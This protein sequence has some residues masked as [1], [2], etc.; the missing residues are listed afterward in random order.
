MVYILNIQGE[1]LMPCK[2]AKARRLL[3]DGKAKVVKREPF[4]LQLLFKCEN[5][6]QDVTLGV[7]AGSTFI[8]WLLQLKH[9]NYIPQK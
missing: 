4:T 1:P 9:T 6:V 3:R 2:N 5:I 8:G 7:D